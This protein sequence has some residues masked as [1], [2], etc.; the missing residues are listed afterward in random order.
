MTLLVICYLD[1]FEVRNRNARSAN[2][3][4]ALILTLIGVFQLIYQ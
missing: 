4:L 3:D 2:T 1:E